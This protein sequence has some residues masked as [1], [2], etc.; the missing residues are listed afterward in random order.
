M[1]WF[2][3][4]EG[5]PWTD[6]R[7]KNPPQ[8]YLKVFPIQI[9]EVFQKNVGKWFGRFGLVWFDCR[10]FADRQPWY[11]S[12][13]KTPQS[14]LNVSKVIHGHGLSDIQRKM[15]YRFSGPLLLAGDPFSI[16]NYVNCKLCECESSG[17]CIVLV[18]LLDQ[19]LNCF[20]TVGCNSSDC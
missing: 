2:C 1:A 20:N 12:P 8:K 3:L 6:S 16:L 5:G 13:I 14:P 18:E 9:R 4:T 17:D 10:Q 7:G 11:K 15:Q 19:I